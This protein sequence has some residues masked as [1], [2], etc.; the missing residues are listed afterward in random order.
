M[1]CDVRICIRL[2]D[3]MYVCKEPTGFLDLLD[4]EPALG[5]GVRLILM[6]TRAIAC[7]ARAVV[8]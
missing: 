3:R 4:L 6:C 5:R 1:N 2:V 8:M 7:R